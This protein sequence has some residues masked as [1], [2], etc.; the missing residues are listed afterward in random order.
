MHEATCAHLPHQGYLAHKKPPPSLGPLTDPRYSPTVGS[1]EG[2]VSYERSTP[3]AEWAARM[4]EA[5]CATVLLLH[6]LSRT[7]G[8]QDNA[9]L[10]HCAKSHRSSYTGL[11]PQ[12]NV[13]TDRDGIAPPFDLD[14]TG[15]RLLR[16]IFVSLHGGL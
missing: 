6:R 8:S 12:R 15:K 10:K 9:A 13:T 5:P 11:Q 3:V 16:E 4:H 14:L 7:E 1:W 2:G